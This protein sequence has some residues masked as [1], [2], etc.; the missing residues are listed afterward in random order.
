MCMN[1]F[2]VD[3]VSVCAY[4]GL[5][6]RTVHVSDIVMRRMYVCVHERERERERKDKKEKSE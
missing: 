4:V 1:I 5:C 2:L 3:C 6:L